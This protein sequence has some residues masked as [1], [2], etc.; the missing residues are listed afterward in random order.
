MKLPHLGAA[1]SSIRKSGIMKLVILER[2][3]VG[4]DVPVDSLGDFGELTIYDNTGYDE[5]P[6]RIKDADIVIANKSRLN[7]E[8]LADAANVKLICEFATGF[9]NVDIDYCRSRKIAVCNVRNYSTDM[10]AQHTFALALYLCEH[11]NYYDNY[12]KS[13]KYALSGKFSHYGEVFSE[14]ASKTWGIVGMG[15]IGRKVASIASS[16]GCRVIHHSITGSGDSGEYE[17]VDKETLLKQSDILSLHCPLS[18]LSRNFIDAKALSLMK[19][20]AYLI[21]VARGPVV[22]GQ[23]LYEA[24]L[25]GRIAGAGLDVLEQEPI[26]ESNPLSKIMDSGKLVITPHMAWASTEARSRCVK[27]TYD[28]IDAFL[29]GEKLSRVD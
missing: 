20:E 8:T 4:M 5:I 18:D 27:L 10:V 1:A 6:S 25:N 11:M 9:D 19:P 28:N 15:N 14:L 22:N 29:K 2:C 7:E 12:V 3:S 23:D 21:N 26:N 13:G 17:T 16:F 24:L